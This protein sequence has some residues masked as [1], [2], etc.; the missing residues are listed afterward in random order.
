MDK[1]LSMGI[2]YAI[3]PVTSSYRNSSMVTLPPL[4]PCLVYV[5]GQAPINRKA[6]SKLFSIATFMLWQK[7]VINNLFTPWLV[8]D[9]HSSWKLDFPT[10]W[11]TSRDA[12]LHRYRPNLP[13]S[14]HRYSA[15]CVQENWKFC[16]GSYFKEKILENELLKI[17]NLLT[18]KR[19]FQNLHQHHLY[20]FFI[21]K[22]LTT[23]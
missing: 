20:H 19:A 6:W 1:Y 9:L 8:E 21:W 16:F 13:Q 11:I 7:D 22:V 5:S 23:K 18:Y 14:S 10:K 15:I 3:L 12:D 4:L 17:T 2:N